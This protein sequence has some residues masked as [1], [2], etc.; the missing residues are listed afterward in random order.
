[1]AV[2]I[3]IIGGWNTKDRYSSFVFSASKLRKSR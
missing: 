3:R 2:G 1:L